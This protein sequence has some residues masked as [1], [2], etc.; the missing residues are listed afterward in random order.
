MSCGKNTR[1]HYFEQLF[2]P[3]HIGNA[4]ERLGL[5]ACVLLWQP[6]T[7]LRATAESQES[8][9]MKPKNI[10]SGVLPVRHSDGGDTSRNQR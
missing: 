9:N 2:E 10:A 8:S 7:F 3:Y 6:V 5:H 1:R 4:L